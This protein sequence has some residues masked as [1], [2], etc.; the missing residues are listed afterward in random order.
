LNTEPFDLEILK[1]YMT[2][3]YVPSPKSI[4]SEE[5]HKMG[6][7]ILTVSEM[8]KSRQNII[9][10]CSNGESGRVC[11]VTGGGIDSGAIV[12]LMSSLDLDFEAV[13][14]GFG[15]PNDETAD[16]EQLCD[17]FGI[18]LHKF[19]S[20]SVL[21]STFEAGSLL[22][23][24]YRGASFCL[25]L[26]RII[27]SQGFDVVFD[28]L[29]VDEFFGGYGFRYE[30]V[31]RMHSEG[32]DRLLAYLKGAN[33]LDFV[34]EASGFFG[35][36][37]SDVR[38]P[39]ARL[40]PY[41]ENNLSFLEQIYMADYN[42]KCVHNFMPLAGLYRAVGLRPV[43]PWLSDPFI[44]FALTIPSDLK[45]DPQTGSTK[46]LFRRAFEKM[47]PKR[48]LT[49][50]KQGFGP[51]LDFVWSKELREAAE[52]TV[53]DGYMVSNGYLSKEFFKEALQSPNPTPVH[54][55]KCWEVYCLEKLLQARKIS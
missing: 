25:D 18:R 11:V 13:T 44:D 36:K 31:L 42:G 35:K 20:K 40:F 30:K 29:G 45:Y 23:I 46:I 34:D 1:V 33:P 19:V 47:L 27:K 50:K 41:F 49:K 21:S 26:S 54:M 53:A 5:T 2:L 3:R 55:T 24:P 48:T 6:G 7:R 38:V 8:R 16:A 14:M 43:Y 28:G 17:H 51:D 52:D 32:T 10:A 12:G 37:L 15:G 9:R 39:W 22:G 4:F